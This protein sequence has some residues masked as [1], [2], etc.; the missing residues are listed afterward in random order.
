MILRSCILA[1]ALL[2]VWTD[3]ARA[4]CAAT[5]PEGL[6]ACI[7]DLEGKLAGARAAL[8][9]AWLDGASEACKTVKVTE[10]RV[11]RS[12]VQRTSAAPQGRA[13]CEVEL[14]HVPVIDGRGAFGS[15]S[16]FGGVPGGF[17]GSSL[18]QLPDGRWAIVGELPGF[19][20][21]ADFLRQLENGP[22]LAI[23]PQ[24]P[25]MR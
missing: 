22:P 5:D 6:R 21:D 11:D 20:G 1:A 8:G 13:D 7:T 19:T 15:G 17:I 12:I 10:G 16:A 23:A 25:A 9:A 3:G 4:A 2:P 24:M 18:M 14:V